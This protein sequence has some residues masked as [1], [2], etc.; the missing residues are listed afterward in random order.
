MT[1]QEIREYAD[2]A[3]VYFQRLITRIPVD[4]AARLTEVWLRE[5]VRLF[6]HYG[7]AALPRVKHEP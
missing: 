7:P 4:V 2:A 1:E 6:E 3:G 5:Q